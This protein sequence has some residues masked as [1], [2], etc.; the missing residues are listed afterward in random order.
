MTEVFF[1]AEHEY[2]IVEGDKG[3]VGVTDYAQNALGDVVYVEVPEVGRVLKQGSVAGVIESVKS[4]SEI[5]S[6]V[7][8]EVLEVNSELEKNPA[9]VNADAEGKGW[10]YKIKI[11]DKSELAKLKSKAE[12]QKHIESH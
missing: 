8:G 7:A 10:I 4:A 9:Q 12:Y 11:A 2:I 6:P 1:T 3:T 5:Y